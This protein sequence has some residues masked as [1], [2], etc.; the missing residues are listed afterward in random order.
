MSWSSHA[1]EHISR[2]LVP[3]R[4]PLKRPTLTHPANPISRPFSSVPT[5]QPWHPA[6]SPD[7]QPFFPPSYFSSSFSHMRLHFFNQTPLSPPT[8]PLHLPLH[9]VSSPHHPCL[10]QSDSLPVI[11]PIHSLCLSL[12]LTFL[13]IDKWR[14]IWSVSFFFRFSSLNFFPSYFLLA[15]QFESNA[16]YFFFFFQF[17]C[18]N[19]IP[20]GEKGTN[21]FFIKA[22][23]GFEC[24]QV[25]AMHWFKHKVLL[26]ATLEVS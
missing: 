13:T 20:H 16:V 24:M 19:K 18:Q 15:L 17:H 10:W 12:P 9:L 5:D 11:T 6:T 1:C 7:Y 22:G 25:Y 3:A 14:P 21:T 26:K 4:W 2:S 8:S 23:D